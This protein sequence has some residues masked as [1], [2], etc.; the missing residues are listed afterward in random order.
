LEIV[1]AAIDATFDHATVAAA[2]LTAYEPPVDDGDRILT[3]ARTIAAHI[4]TRARAQ[5]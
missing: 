5:R 4:A 2:A 3:A 1:L